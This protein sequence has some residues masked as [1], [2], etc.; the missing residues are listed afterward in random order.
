MHKIYLCRFFIKCSQNYKLMYK[1]APKLSLQK[2]VLSVHKGLKYPCSQCN[3][4]STQQVHLQKHMWQFMK[5]LN[6][7]A[8]NVITKQSVGVISKFIRNSSVLIAWNYLPERLFVDTSYNTYKISVY[9]LYLLYKTVLWEW[10]FVETWDCFTV[11]VLCKKSF[12]SIALNKVYIAKVLS[13]F[14]K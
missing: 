5:V 4:K 7:L 1:A 12:Q 8:M 10:T 14:F 6:S 9:L 3:Y 2:N 13:S 11:M